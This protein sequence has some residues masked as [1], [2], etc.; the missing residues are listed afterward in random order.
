VQPTIVGRKSVP[1]RFPLDRSKLA[2]LARA[3]H[4]DDSAWYEES[5]AS[6]AGF[7]GVPTPPTVGV[8]ADHWREGGALAF[9]MIA[10]LDIERV[11]HGEV[12][13]EYLRPLRMGD[14]LIATSTVKDVATRDGKR[15]G[16]M[17]LVTV[18]TDFVNQRG[19][20][21]MRRRDVLIERS[22]QT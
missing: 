9:A 8:L 15:G 5:G 2:E 21:A 18:E 20:L 1:V 16:T 10:E 12:T 7:D 4:D 17:T 13:F 6:A 22:S 19:E 14:E 3:F 11:L